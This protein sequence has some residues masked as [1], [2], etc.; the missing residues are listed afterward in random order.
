MDAKVKAMIKLIEEDADSFARRAEMYYKKR[1]ELMKLVEEFYRAYRALAERYDH[2]TGALRQAHRTMSEAFPNQVP[3]VLA[4]D[5]PASSASEADPRTPE[6]STPVRALFDP[7]DLQKDA[8]GVS[9][10]HFHAAKRNGAHTDDSD[11]VTSRKGLKQLNDLF[12]SG[13]HANF[14]EGRVRKGLNFNDA[15][16]N[17]TSQARSLSESERVDKL[18]REIL[19][20]KEALAKLEKEKE[21]GLVQ[22]QQ[23]LDRLS[24]LESEVSHA[25]EDSREFRERASRAEAEAQTLKEALSRL[26]AEKE[27]SFL[28]YQQCLDKISNLETVLSHAQK[29]A[30]ELNERSTKAESEA[31]S[32]KQDLSKVEA[33]KG[34]AHDKYNNSL[35]MI[36]NLEEQ[37]LQANE[38]SRM[39]SERAEK[40]ESEVET[41]KQAIAKSREEKEAAALQY[42]QCLETISSLEH[43]ISCA[44]E[45]AQRLKAEVDTG[46]A[47]LKGAEERCLMLERSNQSLHSELES[48]V[49]KM[50]TQS[51][52]L[53]EKQKELGRLWACVQEE[54]LRFVEAET[55]FQTLQHLHSQAQDDLRSLVSELQNRDQ[56]LRDMEARNQSLQD[57]SLKLEEENKSLGE[58]KI[59][60]D[61]SIRNLQDEIFTLVETKE[62]LQAEV[63][64]RVD[65]RNALQQEIYCLKEELNDLNKKHQSILVKLDAVGLNSE[66]FESSVKQLQDENSTLQETCQRERCEKAALL[67][68]LEIME[69][70]LQK[71]ALLENSLSDM[72]AELEG[73]RR[74]IKSL[75]ESCQAL[76]EEKST[77]VDEKATLITQLQ[78]TNENL[79]QVLEKNPI[80]ED[81]LSDA[82]NELEV[83]KEKSKSLEESCHLLVDQR[84]GLIG[85]KDT[86]ISQ[87]EM[88]EQTLK[89]MEKGY[90]EVEEKYCAMEK[91]K[92]S[93]LSKIEE[94][95]V[96]LDVQQQKHASF[97]EMSKTQLAGLETQIRLVQEESRN[98]N[99][100]LKEELDKALDSQIEIFVLQKCLQELKENNC[101]VLVECQKL[102]E[103]SKLSEKLISELEQENLDQQMEM[104]SLFHQN[105]TLRTGL[106]RLL[107]ALDIVPDHG[108][109]DKNGH[110]ETRL[111]H[112]LDKVEDTKN[113]L[114]GSQDEND[115][116]AVEMSVLVTLLGQL[117]SEMGCLEMER[118]IID[119]EL[120]I[121]TEQFSTVQSEAQK[122]VGLTEELRLK[123]QEGNR[124]KEVQKTQIEDLRG[125]LLD[126]HGAYE[127]LQEDMSHEVEEKRSMAKKLLQMEEKNSTMEEENCVMFAEMFS[128]SNLSLVLVNGVD[129]RSVVIKDL[130]QDID[131][132]NVMNG[133]LKD[134]STITERRLE[135]VEMENLHLK[136][137]VQKSEH[138][139]K[140]VTVLS[141]QLSHE[142][143]C[144]KNLLHQKEMKLLVAEEKV[145][146]TEDEKAKLH[147][148]VDDL[149]GKYEEVEMIKEDQEKHLLKLSEDNNHLSKENGFLSQVSRQLDAELHQLRDEHENSKL[150]VESLCLEVEKGKNESDIWETQATALFG[151]LQTSSIS[152]ALFEEKVHELTEACQSLQDENTFDDM[153]IELLKERVSI[154]EGE[155]EELKAQL[156]PYGPAIISLTDSIASLENHTCLRTEPKESGIEELKDAELANHLHVERRTTEDPKTAVPNASS[157]LQNLQTRVKAIEKRVIDMERLAMQENIDAQ[158][159]LESVISQMNHL[160][161]EN[162]LHRKNVK[163]TSE[164]SEV[165]SGLLTKDI[166]LDQMSESSS[167]GLS[168]RKNT[169]TDN[170]MLEIWESTDQDS[171]IDLTVGKAKEDKNIEYQAAKQKSE[172]L[173]SDLLAEKELGVDKL[174]VSKRSL[175]SRQGGNKRKVL[176]RL[177]SDVQKLTNLQI[178]VQDLMKKVELIGKNKRGKAFVEC[179]T[180]K[181]QLEEAEETILELFD[182]NENLMKDIENTSLPS[183]KKSATEIE[184]TGS[185]SRRRISEQARRGSERIGRLQLEIQRIQF[186]LLKLDDG[187]ESNG[188]ARI[189]ETKSSVLLRDYLYGG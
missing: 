126:M 165:E 173:P 32:L 25:Q 116:L 127:K 80:L 113:A 152:Q 7:D 177:N 170:K 78:V 117:R 134:K 182:L 35:Q 132:L 75:E 110:D 65:E 74:K 166:M 37:L 181:G 1:P 141:D 73:V 164:I 12:G 159:K 11:S 41:L 49:L 93:A 17:H 77:L 135:E 136:E 47:S 94:L 123:L 104:K 137:R 3:F 30:G 115:L 145:G 188:S 52:E 33:E 64:L 40:A 61:M 89:D 130:V 180:T 114:S 82:R 58:L 44:Q 10:S 161:R 81:S 108:C 155:N 57:K 150:K 8:L 26:E 154:L 103:A 125:N 186:V 144:G 172:L 120:S 14:A 99:R 21:T 109:V 85:E 185:V 18:E 15:V 111:G 142:I 16:D 87:L 106:C 34:V 133:V 13:D 51:E 42:R 28:Q 118:N 31:Q 162:S 169:E 72:G 184:D 148:I 175:E 131:R 91:E 157:D 62:N 55:A 122:L 146:I 88:A 153:N 9:S 174:G 84:S 71:N 107:K 36:S 83:L 95:K 66:C 70:L 86:L 76:L 23:N 67:E 156:A 43:D 147:K 112:I 167:Y 48:L 119:Q 138:E 6:R 79:G 124:V 38:G 59:S 143:L 183:H 97:T 140:T 160:K 54:R 105:D 45:E 46:A 92:E 179:E 63:E 69:Q 128:L 101:S 5:S 39:F 19:T 29:D 171:S 20:L 102:L 68:K 27:V 90:T 151:E 176:E 2:A 178:T 96:S 4:D 139:L 22:Y 121:R 163:P 50:G 98:R 24:K 53:T 187:K 100:E 129:E 158:T 149:K 168:R 60:S 56:V 189:L